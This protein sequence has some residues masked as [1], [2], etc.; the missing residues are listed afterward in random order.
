MP[1][2]QVPEPGRVPPVPWAARVSRPG[3]ACEVEAESVARSVAGPSADA[4]RAA[5]AEHSSADLP[6]SGQPLD[7]S[8]RAFFERRLGYDLGSVRV[9]HDATAQGSARAVGAL[10]Y[11]VG[12]DVVFGAGRYEP[13]GERGRH[14]LAHELV[15]V[16]QHASG[17]ARTGPAIRRQ[18]P[19]PA[20]GVDP[21]PGPTPKELADKLLKD[22][23]AK[24][25]DAAKL[26]PGHRSA[27]ALVTDAAAHGVKFGGYGE[28]GPAKAAWNYTVGDT[29]YV[30]KTRTD[31]YLA[32]N[33]FLFELNNAIREPKFAAVTKEAADK[34]ITPKE[35]A[36][37]KVALEVEGMLRL[38]M[39]W[40]DIKGGDTKLDKYDNDFYADQYR[41]Y[42]DGT[43]TKEQIVDEVLSWK[44]GI[45][46][47]KTN[48]QYYMDQ[49]PK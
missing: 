35:Y 34:K 32:M 46:K 48:E 33:S 45:E 39:V 21:P 5:P 31:P 41:A 49:Y 23:A 37:K 15:H 25:P 6:A 22:F 43:K 8:T 47:S 7:A 11:T 40:F 4:A 26:I 38:G 30:T 42:K 13:R 20:S 14:L 17:R 36:R 2:W 27:E 9:H 1:I 10:A 3:D 24:F 28:D 16:A 19:R 12:S 29:V 18:T 44:N